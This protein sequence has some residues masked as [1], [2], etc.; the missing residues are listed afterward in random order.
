MWSEASECLPLYVRRHLSA[1]EYHASCLG[2]LTIW[3][4]VYYVALWNVWFVLGMLVLFRVATIVQLSEHGC[5]G[6]ECP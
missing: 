2:D 6:L 3:G 4:L 5:T 1:C